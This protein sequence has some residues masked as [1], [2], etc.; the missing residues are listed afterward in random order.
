MKKTEELQIF[1]KNIT[2]LRVKNNLTQ[3]EMAEKLGIAPA[4]ISML[5]QGI[6]PP[7]LGCAIF[8][9]IYKHFG[10]VPKDMFIP[11]QDNI[12]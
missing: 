11:L 12:P 9:S 3:K 4:S 6:V 5:E 2:D 1:C 10:I 7:K 8:V